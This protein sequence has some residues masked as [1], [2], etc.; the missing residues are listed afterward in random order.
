VIGIIAAIIAGVA[1]VGYRMDQAPTSAAAV[2][3]GVECNTQEYSVFHIHAHLDVFVDGQ[4]YTIP[5]QI[6]INDN[7]CLYWLHTH[8]TDGVIHIEAPQTKNFTL[9]Q[10]VDIWKNTGSRPPPSGNPSIF[11]N[12]QPVSGGLSDVQLN[13]HD[14]IT[15]V[16]GTSPSVIP[17][18][19]QFPEGE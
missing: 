8:A 2:I 9:G 6:G 12:G 11:V 3:D 13:A 19:Y 7:T 15:L 10:F 16:Y 1:Y 14:E 17:S 5:A 4:P 18:F